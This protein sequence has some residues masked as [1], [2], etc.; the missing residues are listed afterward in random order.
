M[1]NIGGTIGGTIDL[2]KEHKEKRD[3]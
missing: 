1:V 2:T 3:I